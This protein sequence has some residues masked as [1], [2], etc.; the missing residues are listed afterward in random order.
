MTSLTSTEV[1]AILRVRPRQV[2]ILA[3]S[4]ELRASK[5]GRQWVFLAEDV[6]DYLNRKSNRPRR[7]RRA[8]T[9]A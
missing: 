8:R 5:I 2:R 6:E 9:A 7:K 1:C 4:G 3:N